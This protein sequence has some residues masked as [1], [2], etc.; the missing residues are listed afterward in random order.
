MFIQTKIWNLLIPPPPLPEKIRNRL[1]PPP[2]VADII[3]ERPLI[4]GKE[5]KEGKRIKGKGGIWRRYR[6]RISFWPSPS[7]RS[8]CLTTSIES[9]LFVI[10][11]ICFILYVVLF[12]FLFKSE[13]ALIVETKLCVM[14]IEVFI[15]IWSIRA[16]NVGWPV[17]NVVNWSVL[18]ALTTAT[19]KQTFVCGQDIK[20]KIWPALKKLK[21]WPWLGFNISLHVSLFQ[22]YCLD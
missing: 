19:W 12:L 22:S 11:L 15:E 18:L 14:L 7:K 16:I 6:T 20:L 10:L 4:K 5:K 13:Y 21:N 8:S 17:I 1:A 2:S 9:F 3:C